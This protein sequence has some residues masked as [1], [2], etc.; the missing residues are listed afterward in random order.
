MIHALALSKRAVSIVSAATLATATLLPL[1]LSNTS[2]G[3][4]AQLS[5]R[6]ITLE[7]SE[8][9]ATDVVYTVS[10][11]PATTGN[12][13]SIIIDFCDSPLVGTACTTTGG[14]NGIDTNVA[15]TTLTVENESGAGFG[16]SWTVDYANSTANTLILEDAAGGS[17]TA[18][19]TVS[20]D[21]GD[22]TANNGIDNPTSALAG[23]NP[24][25]D[26]FYARIVTFADETHADSYD[27]TTTGANN[28]PANAIDAG[29]VA[30][31]TADQLTINARVQEVLQFCVGTTDA[32]ST[33]DCADISGTTV[34]LGV[35]QSGAVSI[36]PVATANGGNNTN[37]LAMVR[38]N[39]VNG[40]V[41]DYFAEAV[42]G[43]TATGSGYAG[44]LGALK[45]SG[46]ECTGDGTLGSGSLTD[47]CFNSAGTTQAVFGGTQE[48]F[49]MTA[50]SVDTTN[51]TT[52]NLVRDTEY[53][54]DG[55]NGGGQ[56]WAWSEATTD[57]I[58][59]STG[60]S[61]KVVDD[62]MLVLRFAAQAAVT[63]PTGQYGVTSTYIATASY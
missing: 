15:S 23:T 9:G 4:Y 13:R 52:T 61:V 44:S 19:T 33:N 46:Q 59:S 6:Q 34:D 25:Q 35:I 63:T 43:D 1:L 2:A 60:S 48:G 41:I 27:S 31:S 14:A 57:R 50:S 21:L 49:G 20:F 22:G 17:V 26:S 40:V 11:K 51:G 8:K 24:A 5:E 55:T 53:D 18:G 32:G 38:T 62:E 7:T 36:S 45:V 42:A 54:G 56:G 37:G 39:A 30:M 58:A 3:A 28:P 29:G 10:F 12:I 47:Q 16:T